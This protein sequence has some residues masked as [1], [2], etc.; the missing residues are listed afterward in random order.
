[1]SKNAIV[2]FY[3]GCVPPQSLI[4]HIGQ[5]VV[6]TCGA[7]EDSM[8]AKHYDEEAIINIT[9]K[10]ALR[11]IVF[12]KENEQQQEMG[13]VKVCFSSGQSK[14]QVVKFIKE[15]FGYGLKEAKDIVDEGVITLATTT[16]AYQ[17][18]RDLSANGGCIIEGGDEHYAVA[19]AAVFINGKYPGSLQ[20]RENLVKDFAM[21]RYH[22]TVNA[23]D[24]IEEALL[25]AVQIVKEH[26]DLAQQWINYDLVKII[27]IL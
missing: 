5:L 23:T 4:T 12:G 7:S 15:K 16:D 20:A 25:N 3:D 8:V 18:V 22:D 10:D 11:K 6:S 21:A 1:M 17:F 13:T 19:Q 26:P 14:L 9:S 2:I 24:S 27:A